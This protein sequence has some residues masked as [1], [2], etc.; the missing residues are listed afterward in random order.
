M[1]T[2]SMIAASGALFATLLVGTACNK[3]EEYN[4][5]GTTAENVLTTVAGH[6]ALVNQCYSNLRAMCYGREDMMFMGETGTDIWHAAYDR[7][8]APQINKYKGLTGGVGMVKNVWD[9]FYVPINLCNAAIDRAD[10]AGYSD[11]NRKNAKIAEAKF[12]RA[13]IYWHIVEWYGNVSLVTTET[14]TPVMVA[15][16]SPVSDFYKLIFDDLTFAKNN[17]PNSYAAG[18]NGRATK[19]AA[20]GMLA[21]MYLTYASFLKYHQN[22]EAEAQTYY[23]L[24]STT[25]QEVIA[26]KADYGVELYASYEDLFDPTNNKANTEALYVISHSSNVALEV[27]S[28]NPNRLFQWF[29]SRYSNKIGMKMSLDYSRDNSAY[30][31]PTKYLLELFSEDRD[32]RY[33]AS[34]QEVW[35]ANDDSK[36]TWTNEQVSWFGKDLTLENTTINLGDTAL[37]YT[38]KRI[39]DKSTRKYAVADLDDMYDAD[40]T[41]QAKAKGNQNYQCFPALRKFR[42]PNRADANSQAGFQDIMMMRLAEIYLIAAE[43]EF[44]LGLDGLSY[45]NVLRNRAQIVGAASNLADA[46]EVSAAGGHLDFILDERA[47]EFCGEHLR[48][49]DLKR[50]KQL[51][52]RLGANIVNGKGNPNIV[53]FDKGKHY[54][55]PIPLTFLQSLENAD[56]FGDNPGY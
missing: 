3:L 28:G 32:A 48:W 4:P 10:A 8:Y 27:N 40:G 23:Q 47:R 50:T 39:S 9:R 5:S 38:K 12:L 45:V 13:Y 29:Q 53:D 2:I 31:Q 21:R 6:E 54:V 15:Y 30:M 16:R 1:K 26:A 14:T 44:H 36:L 24:A 34:F 55:R 49:F 51:E 18:E 37:L 56:E 20:H 11:E 22:N 52:N 42:A 19:K 43:A 7:D 46:A 35:L 25:A 17:L 41:V 33:A